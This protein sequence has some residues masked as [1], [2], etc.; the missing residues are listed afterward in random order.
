MDDDLWKMLAKVIGRLFP[1]SQSSLSLAFM[2]TLD[3]HHP[4]LAY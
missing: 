3:Y 1:A 2:L 4:I